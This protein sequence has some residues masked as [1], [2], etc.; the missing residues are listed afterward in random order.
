VHT[1][2]QKIYSLQE[3]LQQGFLFEEDRLIKNIKDC[4][5][6]SPTPP[7]AVL[8]SLCVYLLLEAHFRA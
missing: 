3:Y 2:N 8:S 4:D 7:S 5:V 1:Q 6:F